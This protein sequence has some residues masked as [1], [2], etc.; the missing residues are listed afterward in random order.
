MKIQI[1]RLKNKKIALDPLVFL[2][3]LLFFAVFFLPSFIFFDQGQ[4]MQW[5]NPSFH[6]Q[7]FSIALPQSLLLLYVIY[8]RE[9]KFSPRYGFFPAFKISSWLLLL[10]LIVVLFLLAALSSSLA[11]VIEGTEMVLPAFDFRLSPNPYIHVLALLSC[12]LTG[13]REELFF[14]SYL[15]TEYQ[16]SRLPMVFAVIC[17]NL[18]FAAGHLYQGL[19]GFFTAFSTGLLLSLLFLWKRNL[20]LNAI[21]HGLYN[22]TVLLLSQL[23]PWEA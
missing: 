14:R 9:K 20:H 4:L 13:Y 17:F 6:M 5:N 22:Y 10:P 15:L 21:G 2:E 3:I 18:L 16:K 8:I 1:F 11:I 12:L 19:A 7:L 23:A